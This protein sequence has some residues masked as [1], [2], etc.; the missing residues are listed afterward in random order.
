MYKS[1][2][3]NI[4]SHNIQIRRKRNHIIFIGKYKLMYN[5]V[6]LRFGK[7]KHA[8]SMFLKM[9]T[10]LSM[11]LQE[12]AYLDI[13]CTLKRLKHSLIHAELGFVKNLYDSSIESRSKKKTNRR[14]L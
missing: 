14:T 3:G 2:L 8:I 5:I 4:A 1:S 6:S 13:N 11:E 7:T 12:G 9:E 10:N